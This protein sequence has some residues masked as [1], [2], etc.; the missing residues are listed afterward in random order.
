MYSKELCASVQLFAVMGDFLG[1]ERRLPYDLEGEFG[2]IVEILFEEGFFLRVAVGHADA[3][4]GGRD[5][6]GVEEV[7]V[8]AAALLLED[9]GESERACGTVQIP[10]R[11]RVLR[12]FVGIV[13]LLDGD[14]RG[15][16]RFFCRAL[17]D[18]NHA[19][20]EGVEFCLVAA[21]RFEIDRAKFC[22]DVGRRAAR[23]ASRVAGGLLV[24]APLRH[25]GEDFACG[26][27]GVASCVGVNARVGRLAAHGDLDLIL[28]RRLERRHAGVTVRVECKADV[29]VQERAVNVLRAV[30][31]A[32]LGDGKDDLQIAVRDVLLAQAAQRFEDG[33]DARLVIRSE[34]GC[35]VRA[36]HAV[37]ELRAN[38]R[39]RLY[40]VHMCRQHD[41]RNTGNRSLEIRDDV[42]AVA[43]EDFPGIV[44]MNLRG[45][46]LS[47]PGGEQIAH[48][49]FVEGGAADGDEREELVQ[50]SFLVDHGVTLSIR[51]RAQS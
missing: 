5:A 40:T 12:E 41:G 49:P 8:G 34:N 22:D 3:E 31:A 4:D 45:A 32:L 17:G 35:T 1:F 21:A 18:L 38:T 51:G 6:V 10:D 47:Q 28:A 29:G 27:D 9:D 48:F 39:A 43:A 50:N 30:H 42:A 26:D 23:D 11:A 33:D 44:L 37:H 16:V 2:G 15:A 46:E 24:D 20:G 7:R 14:G 25:G 13:V 36:D 19:R